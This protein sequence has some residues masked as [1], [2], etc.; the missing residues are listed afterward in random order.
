VKA[1]WS[2]AVYWPSW[3]ALTF[4]LFLLR[5]AWAISSR[6]PQDT[7]SDFVWR[8]LKI[9]SNEPV[10]KWNATDYLVCGAWITVVTWLTFHFFL[11]KFGLAAGGPR[12]RCGLPRRL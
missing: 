8:V 6:H 10:L 3:M 7:L 2:A 4:S 12:G 11:R 5:E 1:L 9:T